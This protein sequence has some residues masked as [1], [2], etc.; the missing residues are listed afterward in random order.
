ME[1]CKAFVGINRSFRDIEI[2]YGSRKRDRACHFKDGHEEKPEIAVDGEV[3][4]LAQ[5]FAED[6]AT[7]I[8][9]M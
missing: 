2:V 5:Y 1:I 8:K 9:S 4:V 6:F 7:Q 3:T